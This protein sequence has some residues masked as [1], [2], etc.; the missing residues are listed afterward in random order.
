[1]VK[2]ATG[3]ARVNEIDDCDECKQL[4]KAI[5]IYC[6]EELGNMC[7]ESDQEC[8]DYFLEFAKDD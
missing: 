5:T 8:V 1:M 3:N 7:F 2:T 4:R 6:R